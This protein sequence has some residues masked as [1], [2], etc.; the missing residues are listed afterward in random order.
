MCAIDGGDDD[1]DKYRM[2]QHAVSSPCIHRLKPDTLLLK[3]AVGRSVRVGRWMPPQ[4]R[5]P[6]GGRSRIAV[7]T[8]FCIFN[9]RQL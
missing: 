2:G 8:S 1:T 7:F 9:I 6:H 4:R 5:G 3:N